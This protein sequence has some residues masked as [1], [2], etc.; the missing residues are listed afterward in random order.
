MANVTS[1]AGTPGTLVSWEEG[2]G[3]DLLFSVCPTSGS[4][5]RDELPSVLSTEVRNDLRQTMLVAPTGA[6]RRHA[7]ATDFGKTDAR[8]ETQYV[9]FGRRFEHSAELTPALSSFVVLA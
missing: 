4:S 3:D 8:K 7:I 6:R 2:I 9:A 1:R 5:T